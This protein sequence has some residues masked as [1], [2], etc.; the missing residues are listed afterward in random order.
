M[1][2][3]PNTDIDFISVNRELRVKI[4]R[5]TTLEDPFIAGSNAVFD[6]KGFSSIRAYH[7]E[8]G[9]ALNRAYDML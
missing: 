2:A 4:E 5:A 9:S 1:C 7:F 6:T 3:T 8:K